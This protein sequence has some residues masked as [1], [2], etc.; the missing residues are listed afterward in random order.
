MKYFVT[1]VNG[2]LII[3]EEKD[4]YKFYP[5]WQYLKTEELA[6]QLVKEMY[7]ELLLIRSE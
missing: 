7:N 5:N 4:G 6:Q 1:L 3:K 2:K